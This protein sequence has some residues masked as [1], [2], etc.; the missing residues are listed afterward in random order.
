MQSN[1]SNRVTTTLLDYTVQV[2]ET[3][4]RL[5]VKVG[6]EWSRWYCFDD[7]FDGMRSLHE[8]FPRIGQEFYRIGFES[9]PTTRMGDE[10][11]TDFLGTPVRGQVIKNDKGEEQ[12]YYNLEDIAAFVGVSVETIKND[13]GIE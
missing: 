1:N 11:I 2:E 4:R 5:R 13:L 8:D 10:I 3:P 12:R 7:G 6:F 9:A